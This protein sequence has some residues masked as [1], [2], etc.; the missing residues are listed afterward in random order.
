MPIS[1]VPED[2]GV[3]F[4]AG[5]SVPEVP[6]GGRGPP[7]TD[8]S[9]MMLPSAIVNAECREIRCVRGW[10]S[11]LGPIWIELGPRT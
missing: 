8:F 9:A 2:I 3:V 4:D 1:V 10:I 7:T 6:D 5:E 11:T